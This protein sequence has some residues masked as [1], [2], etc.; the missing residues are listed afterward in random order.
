MGADRAA[1]RDVLLRMTDRLEH[2]GP[3]GSGVLVDGSAGLGHRR[4]AIIDLVSGQQPMN[5]VDNRFTIVYN[6]EIYNYLE[7]REDLED[8]GERLRTNSDTEVA[9]LAF[10]RWGAG[11]F[12]RFDGMFALAIWDRDEGALHLARDRF[13]IKPLFYVQAAGNFAFASE[14]KALRE[15][16]WW[17]RELDPYAFDE[18][19]SYGVIAEPRT[20]YEQVR[21]FPPST[22]GSARA[23]QRQQ[24]STYWEPTFAPVG[25]SRREGREGLNEAL[26]RSVRLCLRS[27]VPVGAFLS[28][29]LDS[30]AVVAA[31]SE[32]LGSKLQT[33]SVGFSD[34]A[35][36]NE[37]PEALTI[38]HHCNSVHH[39][40]DMVLDLQGVPDLARGVLQAHDQP[41]ADY[42]AMPHFLVADFASKRVKTVLSGDGGDEVFG[43]YP[44]A[45]APAV[46]RMYRRIPGPLRR[47]VMAPLVRRLPTSM[48]RIS[49]D[50]LAKRFVRGAELPMERA[51]FAYKEWLF[52]EEKQDVYAP[53]FR[54]RLGSY[55]A[56]DPT[57]RCFA[58]S[59]EFDEVNRLLQADQR[60]FLL[61][62][63]LPKVDRASM[64]CSLEVRVPLLS[65]GV[66]DFLSTVPP[67]FK[68]RPGKTK[69]LLRDALRDR[70]P[71][72]I[73]REKKKGFTP[74]LSVWLKSGL[75]DWA[76][77][78]LTSRAFAD[79]NMV[80]PSAAIGYLRDHQRGKA[81]HNRFLWSC[82]MLGLWAEEWGP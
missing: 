77:E 41:F 70:L 63:N 1:D 6:G 30:G 60:T 18:Y 40:L 75:H 35:S 61:N 37:L 33:F 58:E 36:Y 23:G 8:A 28:G 21:A 81:D 29:G 67:E 64:A 79:M 11:A 46:A 53:D 39:Q 55:D 2:R 14:I 25:M 10:R 71:G 5:T 38:A 27:D 51:H 66:V 52:G 72:S 80:V 42:S 34:D 74:P 43:G 68:A 73:L 78:V 50:Y 22:C 69:V 3:D 32:A 7:I 13:G 82:V 45:Y 47:A 54:S 48:A 16:D 19:F 57:G 59:G 65:N 17:D 26:E 20:A 62:D 4:L 49:F 9:L 12:R 15:L 76:L 44:T 56:F 31:A 24:L